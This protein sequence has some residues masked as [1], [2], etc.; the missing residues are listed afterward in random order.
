MKKLY[1]ITIF[2]YP[3]T[4]LLFPVLYR[5]FSINTLPPFNAQTQ[6]VLIVGSILLSLCMGILSLYKKSAPS[7]RFIIITN[8]VYVAVFTLVLCLKIV[9]SIFS[10]ISLNSLLSIWMHYSNIIPWVA[11][12]LCFSSLV[13]F[14]SLKKGEYHE[15]N[16]SDNS[17][18][19]MS[20]S[21]RSNS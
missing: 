15:K 4:V 3:I 18:V 8:I 9:D 6:V 2:V 11:P 21:S 16:N 10:I 1:V 12:A 5:Y 17:S 7:K 13:L 20:D 14:S 19:C